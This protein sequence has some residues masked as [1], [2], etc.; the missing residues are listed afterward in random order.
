M[1]ITS[2]VGLNE[3]DGILGIYPISSDKSS[4]YV[5]NYKDRGLIDNLMI[6]IFPYGA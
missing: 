5:G 1:G 4:S 3:F 2:Q 6:S